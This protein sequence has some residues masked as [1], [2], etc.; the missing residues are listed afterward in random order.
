M[1]P[2]YCRIAVSEFIVFVS[3]VAGGGKLLQQKVGCAHNSSQ[4]HHLEV[5]CAVAFGARLCLGGNFGAISVA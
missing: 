5:A 1:N 3:N 4:S 2:F